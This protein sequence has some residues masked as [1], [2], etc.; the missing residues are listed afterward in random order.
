MSVHI[1]NRDRV[2]AAMEAE[3]VGPAPRG[4]E[5]D[6]T[7]VVRFA[8]AEESYGPWRQ[9]GSGE[10]ILERDRPC[11]RYGVGVLYPLETPAEALAPG[12]GDDAASAPPAT[13]GDTGADGA[14]TARGQRDIEAIVERNP[15]QPDSGDDEAFDL[16]TANT[17]RP[18]SAGLSFLAAIPPGS[19][20]VVSATGGRYGRKAVTIAGRERTWWLRGPVSIRAEFPADAVRT[21][22]EARVAPSH[23]AAEN[24]AG[25]DLH[26]ELYSRPHDGA[27]WLITA[28]LVNRKRHDGVPDEYC[29]FQTAFTATVAVGDDRPH[30]LPYPGPPHEQL[31]EEERSLALLYRNTQTFAVGHG[32]AADWD[33]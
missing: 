2:L 20:L 18:S 6:C 17:Y 4:R 7:R 23:V 26:I 1:P 29:L 31:D 33:A 28:S 21:A 5:I 3:L 12:G 30:I 19:T 27:G 32:C 10:E 8:T 15:G 24:T 22:R 11:T 9:Q 13:D 16:F 25:L 14:V